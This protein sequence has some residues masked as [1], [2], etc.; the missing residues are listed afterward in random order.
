M[1]GS[2]ESLAYWLQ[3]LLRG[4]GRF[5]DTLERLAAPR[6]LADGRESGYGLGLRH[7][8]IDGRDFI[9]HGGSHPGYK[10]YFLLDP[11]E[12]TGFV[13]VSNREDTNGNKIATECMA[14]LNGLA[15]PAASDALTDGFYV[16]ES[17]PWW[18]EVKGST[19][20]YLDADDTVYDDGEGWVSS[21]SASSPM[22][23]RMED[24]AVVG[25]IGHA[26]RRLLPAENDAVD[27][28]LD[29]GWVSTEGA[30]FEIE[31]GEVVMGVGPIRHRMPLRP[32]GHGRYIFT[33]HDGPWTKRVCMNV[34]E[35]DKVEL[36]L[37]RA[38]MMEYRRAAHD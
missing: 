21:R 7:T 24:G 31:D 33:L 19:V 18:I 27:A 14:A 2:A 28:T 22:R 37:S 35:G 15:L 16:T 25:E 26:A 38:R 8:V 3:S 12:K 13:V 36:V 29:G 5:E 4:E 6:E 17:G 20:T 23:L 30:R 11:V 32:L 1:T 10:T 34:L 9:G